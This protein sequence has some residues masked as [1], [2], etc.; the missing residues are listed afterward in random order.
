MKEGISSLLISRKKKFGCEKYKLSG[1]IFF[2]FEFMACI[3]LNKNKNKNK[4][5]HKC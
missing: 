5:L 2:T 3:E 1:K 4:A